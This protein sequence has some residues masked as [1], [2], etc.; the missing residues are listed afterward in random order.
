VF[1]S[2]LSTRHFFSQEN[3]MPQLWE[4]YPVITKTVR[5]DH[6]GN[7]A[8]GGGH[9]FLHALMVA[10]YGELIAD[11]SRIGELAWLAGICHNTDRIFRRFVEYEIRQQI[12]SY[13]D[14]TTIPTLAEK[15][16][17]IEAVMNHSKF[18]D[19]ADNPIT[20]TLK[21]ADR[22]ANIGPLLCVR[23]GQHFHL[24]PAFDPRY[25]DTPDPTSTYKNPKTVWRDIMLSSEW[26]PW[27][28]LPKAKK[29]AEPWFNRLRIFVAGFPEQVRE[30][31]LDP[32]PFP[33]DF[34][35]LDK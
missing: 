14:L 7:G 6:A 29:L 17:I 15:D 13:L 3:A 16:D 24:L 27:L 10:Q 1:F 35:F 23:S 5:K 32:Y 25:L 12:R 26:E 30:V 33:E 31:G 9:D 22:L 34:D 21:D 2:A 11:E 20:V 8:I 18:N 28:R 4:K 19:P